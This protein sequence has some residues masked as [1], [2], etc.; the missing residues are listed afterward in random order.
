M[1]PVFY[2]PIDDDGLR[3]QM[4]GGVTDD[5]EVAKLWCSH[6]NGHSEEVA[7][8]RMTLTVDA[9]KRFFKQ[10]R[11]ALTRTLRNERH[12]GIAKE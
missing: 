1:R 9:R 12:L 6:H 10:A 3:D 7:L 2:V 11:A 8:N 5:P 4:V